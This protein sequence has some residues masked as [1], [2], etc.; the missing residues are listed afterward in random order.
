MASR[1]MNDNG[2]WA[3]GSADRT[4]AR[5]T[6]QLSPDAVHR[7]TTNQGLTTAFERKVA[8]KLSKSY[9]E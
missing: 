7:W 1:D 6:P 5:E 9:F 3:C 2:N 4:H 8:S